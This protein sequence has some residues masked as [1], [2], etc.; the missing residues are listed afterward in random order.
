VEP[1]FKESLTGVGFGKI[2]LNSMGVY[3]SVRYN[4]L[5]TV[6]KP[7]TAKK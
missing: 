4:P 1:F 6:K 5:R 3:F 2:D 7:A